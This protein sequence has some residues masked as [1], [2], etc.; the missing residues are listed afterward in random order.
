M[1]YSSLFLCVLFK[2]MLLR[3]IW[4]FIIISLLLL[5]VDNQCGIYVKAAKQIVKVDNIS[6]V[7]DALNFKI[8]YGQTFKVI[9]NAIDGKSYLL[10]QNNSRMAARTKYCTPRMKSFVVPLSNYSLDTDT[11]PGIPG[12]LG[13]CKGIT[14][15]DS[16]SQCLLKLYEGGELTMVNKTEPEQLSQFSAYFTSAT[17]QLQACNI[18]TFVPSSED[19]PLQRAE[20]IKYLAV[21]G[22]LEVR[23]NSV[24]NAVKQNYECLAKSAASKN[25]TFKPVVGWMLFD[26]GV[27]F[28]TT[29]AYKTKFVVDAGGVN[30]DESINKMTYNISA[31]DDLEQLHAILCSV[32]VVIDE[33]Y[34]PDPA[35]YNVSTFLQ[36]IGVEDQSC[37]AF[38]TRQSIWRYDKK[39]H[40]GTSLDW[41]DS[42]VSQPQLVLA[43]LMEAIFPTGNYTTTYLRNLSKGE[44]V[45]NTTNSDKC[46]TNAFSPLEPTIVPCQ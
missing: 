6:T 32:D 24:Y 11:F 9:K 29:E 45:S 8:Y 43:D 30:V 38:L 16:A 39:I 46:D 13:T 21:F 17:D 20:W 4:F 35:A 15:Y 22:N 26:N 42:G 34:T 12:L 3:S 37:F 7:D 28:F 40:N 41:Y 36:N 10:I 18:A 5:L 31:P 1:C 2:K 19:Y 27:W 44:Q 25:S 14:A 33:T 23:A